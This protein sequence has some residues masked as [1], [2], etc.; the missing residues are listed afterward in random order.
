MHDH[1]W[2][3]VDSDVQSTAYKVRL[4]N[5]TIKENLGGVVELLQTCNSYSI[6]NIIK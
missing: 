3:Q 5:A 6:Y 2:Y 1:Y 4:S